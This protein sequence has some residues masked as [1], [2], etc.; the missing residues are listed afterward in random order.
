MVHEELS[1]QIIGCCMA[2]HNSLG[3]GLL[4]QCYHNA[5]F[6]ELQA[7]G[8]KVSYN[9]PF[10]VEHRGQVVGEYLADLL[11]EGKVIVELKSVKRL[12]DVHTAQVINYL[13]VSGC[14]LGLLVNFQGSVLEWKRLVV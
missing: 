11:V 14:S 7:A 9:A 2:V 4:E 10:T 8:L 3:P 6:F 12:S 13:H 1:F 5:L